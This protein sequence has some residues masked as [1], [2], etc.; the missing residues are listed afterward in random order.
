MLKTE[1]RMF[2]F[3]FLL[4]AF[5]FNYPVTF[6]S[7]TNI[8]AG[9]RNTVLVYKVFDTHEILNQINLIGLVL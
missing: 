5:F 8:L 3:Y 7:K 4:M 9:K 1:L 2:L 6:I